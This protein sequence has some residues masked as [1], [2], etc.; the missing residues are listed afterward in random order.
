MTR[1]YNG[2]KPITGKAYTEQGLQSSV[3]LVSVK[4]NVS[5]YLQRNRSPNIFEQL[6]TLTL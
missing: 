1:M 2:D 4:N 3:K 5:Y 6:S